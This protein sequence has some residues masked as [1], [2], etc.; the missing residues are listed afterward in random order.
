MVWDPPWDTAIHCVPCHIPALYRY[1]PRPS[2]RTLRARRYPLGPIYRIRLA[3][4]VVASADE[5][6]YPVPAV[7]SMMLGGCYAQGL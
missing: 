7:C 2:I 5:L 4:N 1:G 6:V 3:R